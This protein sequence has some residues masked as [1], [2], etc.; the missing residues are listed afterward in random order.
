[1]SSNFSDETQSTC[2]LISKT[3]ISLFSILG[4]KVKRTLWRAGSV[5]NLLDNTITNEETSEGTAE[6]EDSKPSNVTSHLST[7]LPDNTFTGCST[8][9]NGSEHALATRYPIFRGG[10]ILANKV[11][12]C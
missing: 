5:R 6:S 9:E 1:M 10:K 11:H 8:Q 2:S 7:D 4:K 12:L 3:E